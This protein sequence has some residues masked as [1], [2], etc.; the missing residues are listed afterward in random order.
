MDERITALII[1]MLFVIIAII[2]NV[3]EWIR[4][5]RMTKGGKACHI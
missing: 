2:L 1:V 5:K 4:K 3:L